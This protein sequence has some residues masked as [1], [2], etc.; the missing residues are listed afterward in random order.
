MFA[1]VEQDALRDL[2]HP[3]LSDERRLALMFIAAV[4]HLHRSVAPA[5]FD[6][7]RR[8]TPE[9]GELCCVSC[10]KPLRTPAMYCCDRCRDA[11]KHIRYIR[12][13]I[14]DERITVPDL[15]E[16]IGARLLYIGSGGQSRPAGFP[17]D[18]AGRPLEADADPA[19]PPDA[20][21]SAGGPLDPAETDRILGEMAFRVASPLPL[22]ACDDW[23]TWESR[24]REIK[25]ARRGIV[26]D[27]LGHAAG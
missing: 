22:R 4:R 25:A 7:R 23:R 2:E 9:D 20:D 18:P 16:S 14:H 26:E 21:E 10:D 8:T 19:A 17:F 27:R 3:D 1:R 12:K 13:I 5:A 11:A 24:Q 15:Q 6:A